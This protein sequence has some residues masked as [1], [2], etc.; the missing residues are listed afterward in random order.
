M[1]V[2]VAA[3]VFAVVLARSLLMSARVCLLGVVLC[4]SKAALSRTDGAHLLPGYTGLVLALFVTLGA[5]VPRGVKIAV[6]PVSV[7]L[8]ALLAVNLPILPPR[9]VALSGVADRRDAWSPCPT[10]RAS[11]HAYLSVHELEERVD[12]EEEGRDS[13][14]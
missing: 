1:I 13:D 5:S 2:G 7:V 14:R 10:P 11:A 4:M 9:D 12:A 3:A 8:T 6:L